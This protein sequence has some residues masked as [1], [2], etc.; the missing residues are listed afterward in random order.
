MKPVSLV[1]TPTRNRRLNEL[2]GLLVLACAVLLFLSLVSYRPTDPSLNTVGSG[3]VRNWIGPAGAY[4]SD[5]FLQLEGLSTFLLPILLGALGW[6]W[7]RSRPA[8]SPGSKSIGV[9]LSL[10]FAPALF[11]LIPSH[12][13]FLYGLPVA[14]LTGR[15]IA[16]LLVRFLNFPGA[17]IVTVT[18]VAAAIYLSTT[19]SFN[20]AREWLGIKLAFLL[21]WRDRFSNWRRNRAQRRE[22]KAAVRLD[23]TPRE[24]TPEG[25]QSRR[26]SSNGRENSAASGRSR[27]R[28][29]FRIA[30]TALPKPLPRS[31]ASKT[32]AP[33]DQA[34]RTA[35]PPPAQPATRSAPSPACAAAVKLRLRR[36]HR[37]SA[38]APIPS[39][40]PSPSPPKTYR[41]SAFPPAPSFIAAT[42][43]RL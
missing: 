18:L 17:C 25:S 38:S 41:D 29:T 40:A 31:P 20:T 15:L 43:P 9:V 6:T 33:A 19:F 13:T 34:P 21:A 4:L 28:A 1:L 30:S 22:L 36:P 3:P 10:L 2:V 23:K 7:M 11:G 8:G 35:T 5:F 37:P 14:G 26:K 24:G 27:R 32:S 39:S 42:T 12:P 16:D